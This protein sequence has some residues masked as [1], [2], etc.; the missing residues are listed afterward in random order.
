MI[1]NINIYENKIFSQN[2]EDGIIEAIFNQIGTINKYFVEFGVQNG[3]E[4]NTRYLYERKGWKGL[5]MDCSNNKQKMIKN[6][7][8]TA[9]NIN[10]LFLKYKVPKNFDLL[11]IDID[12]NDYWVWKSITN[13]YPRVVI[14]EYNACVPVELSKVVEYDPEFKWDFT[15]YF[16]ASILALFNMGKS[17]GYT[18]IGCE[19]MGINAFFVLN[20]LV[21]GN[22]KIKEIKKLYHLP[23]YGKKEY[24]YGFR[25]S[26]RKMIDID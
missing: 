5:M 1:G 3:T 19:S 15:D 10:D 13:Y 17:K 23:R 22:F 16:G 6:E 7:F 20:D 25:P 18:L 21:E 9:E 2:G 14:I 11:S 12:G 4:C 26:K 8:I 24:N